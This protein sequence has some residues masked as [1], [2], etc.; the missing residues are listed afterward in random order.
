L[1]E[2]E[3]DMSDTVSRAP[4]VGTSEVVIVLLPLMAVVLVVFL[5]TGLAIPVLPLHVRQGLG[6]GTFVVGLVTG[7]QFAASLVSRVWSGHYADR[8]GAKRAVVVGLLAAAVS[9]LVYV[10]SLQFVHAPVVSAAILLLGR[11]LLG[12]AESFIITGALSWG[13]ALVAARNSGKVIA[14]IGTAMY[15]AFAVGAPAGT[16]LYATHGFL[17]IALATTIVPLATVLLIMPLSPVAPVPRAQPPLV[18]VADAV[19]LPGI[20]LSFSS[21]GFGA[22]TTFST[23]LFVDRGWMPA[24][25][26]LTAFTTSFMVARVVFGHLPDKMGGAKV[27]LASVWLEAAG[28]A[29]IW[30]APWSTLAS[31]GA[32]L[33]GLGYALVYPGLGL[34]AVRRVPPQSRGLAMGTYTAFFDLGIGI[35]SPLLGLI[36]GGA[37]LRSVF[38]VSALVVLG[39]AAIAI[40][41]LRRPSPTS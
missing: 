35:T 7:S 36:A 41:L 23:L 29:L 15:A 22:I 13:L 24:W 39:A 12:G 40:R 2:E 21:L 34:E 16:A 11:A 19:L 28:L 10:V 27:A 31:A 5:I 38:L 26:A 20:G 6:L 17:A 3:I 8:G 25:I 37:G 1:A 18:T 9:G 33:T 32:L 14:W 4:A 30:I